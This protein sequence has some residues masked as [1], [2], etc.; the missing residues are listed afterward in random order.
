MRLFLTHN[1]MR[2]EE[3]F[4]KFKANVDDLGP[5]FLKFI[6]EFQRTREGWIMAQRTLN[7]NKYPAL[8]PVYETLKTKEWGP[9]PILVRSGALIAA[10]RGG[11]GWYQ[12]IN[13]KYMSVGIN[14]PYASFHQD[15]TRKI[16]RRNY[17]LTRDGN[18]TKVDYAQLIQ[19][20]EGKID[21]DIQSILN[22]S[23]I[24]IAKVGL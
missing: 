14:L 21:E 17:F 1:F 10:V 18:L 9:K 2:L 22:K 5:A 24:D 3:N 7:A 19:A 6:P 13:E 15:G 8:S 12:K 16:P 11:D 4:I 20:V 23:S